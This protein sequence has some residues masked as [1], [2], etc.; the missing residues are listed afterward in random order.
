MR[1]VLSTILAVAAGRPVETPPQN[2][3]VSHGLV[4]DVQRDEECQVFVKLTSLEGERK[5][6]VGPISY[7]TSPIVRWQAGHGH[8]WVSGSAEYGSE[9][10]RYKMSAL[11]SGKLFTA[12]GSLEGRPTIAYMAE[13]PLTDVHSAARLAKFPVETYAGYVPVSR[14]ETRLFCLSNCLPDEMRLTSTT[15]VGARILTYGS[16]E[17]ST[18]KW[19]FVAFQY[20]GRRSPDNRKWEAGRWRIADTM[21]V[22]FHEAFQVLAKADAYYFVTCSGKLYRT[23]QPRI[24]TGRRSV[25]PIWEDRTRPITHFLTDA[26]TDR[27]FLFCKPAKDGET[28]VFFELAAKPEPKPYDLS[29]VKPSKADEPLKGVLERAR[30]LA[31]QKLLRHPEPPKD[32]KKP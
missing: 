29:K 1:T 16:D 6:I 23:G 5:A 2:V 4:V 7:S 32:E 10:H 3:V 12:E 26:D 31:D 25:E 20:E 19:S 27:T 9:Y 21:S 24:L 22:S 15:G 8:F 18:P 13:S 30:F 14:D 11:I 17:P 28:G